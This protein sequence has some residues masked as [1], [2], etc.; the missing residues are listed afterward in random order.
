MIFEN[1][2]FGIN[3]TTHPAPALPT[4]AYAVD[5]ETVVEAIFGHSGNIQ[6]NYATGADRT[7][8]LRWYSTQSD[9]V[10][11]PGDWIADV[12]YERNAITV[13]NRFLQGTGLGV[14]NPF[15]NGEWDNLP[16]QRC[17]WYQVTKVSPAIDDPYTLAMCLRFVRWSC[18]STASSRPH[19]P[20]RRRYAR[21]VQRGP[22][23]PQRRQRH[24]PAIH[25]ARVGLGQ[26]RRHPIIQCRLASGP[27]FRLPVP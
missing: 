12:T 26:Y 19:A 15:N 5:G 2:P 24:P 25:H 10:V 21:R 8:L 1:R 4:G 20:E 27:C 6:G 23:R 22:D 3:A 18:T 11:R 16:A 9:P 14:G 13:Q 17:F 7:V